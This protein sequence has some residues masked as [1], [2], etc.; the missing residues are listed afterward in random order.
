PTTRGK[1]APRWSVEIGRASCR[2]RVSLSVV[3][4]GEKNKAR[5]EK[6][7]TRRPHQ[8][9]LALSG[10]PSADLLVPV[11]V[12]PADVADPLAIQTGG[13]AWGSKITVPASGAGAATRGTAAGRVSRASPGG[14]KRR[15]RSRTTFFF[16]PEP[17]YELTR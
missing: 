5:T 16:K 9:L 6:T 3:A 10:R 4:G 11:A 17:A 14:E 13:R 1:P 15:S 2:E 8:A 12:V 7:P